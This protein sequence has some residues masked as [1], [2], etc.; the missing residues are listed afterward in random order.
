LPTRASWL[1]RIGDF[2][3]SPGS[4]P[5][6]AAVRDEC[7]RQTASSRGRS[8]VL[9]RCGIRIRGGGSCRQAL[10]AAR[11]RKSSTFVEALRAVAEA[12]PVGDC[13]RL[14]AAVCSELPKHPL[15]VVRHRLRADDKFTC[16]LLRPHRSGEQP[17][18]LE[19]SPCQ[20]GIRW[21]TVPRDTQSG[22]PCSS[23]STLRAV[24]ECDRG[25]PRR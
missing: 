8:Q 1:L 3:L 13:D 19:L 17:Q 18:H 25:V 22:A 23:S 2:S 14:R 15:D 5:P 21:S 12:L 20:R 4:W 16:D 6:L 7:P 24:L 10:I 11:E 9:V